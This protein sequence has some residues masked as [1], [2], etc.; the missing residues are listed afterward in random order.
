MI[1]ISHQHEDEEQWKQLFDYHFI[2]LTNGCKI[3]RVFRC[4]CAAITKAVLQVASE[5]SKSYSTGLVP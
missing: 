2:F 1:N 3:T 4:L 5:K